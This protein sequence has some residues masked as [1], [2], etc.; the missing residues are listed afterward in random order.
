MGKSFLR[1][2]LI[3]VIPIDHP[4]SRV[5]DYLKEN[6]NSPKETVLFYY[7]DYTDQVNQTLEKLAVCLLRQMLCTANYIPKE[8]QAVYDDCAKR[9]GSPDFESL[10]RLL[11]LCSRRF[12]TI[13]LVFDALDESQQ[14]K[15]KN[16]SHSFPI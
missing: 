16:S 2:A 3:P 15:L 1:Y 13:H 4:S 6:L 5:I 7:F 11:D 10:S 12:S 9:C 8:I 14:S